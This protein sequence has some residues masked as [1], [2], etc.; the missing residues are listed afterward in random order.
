MEEEGEGVVVLA[1]LKAAKMEGK[2]V[3]VL[4]DLEVA[5]MEDMVA[6]QKDSHW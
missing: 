3:V 2:E 1:D 4:A 5:N 6:A